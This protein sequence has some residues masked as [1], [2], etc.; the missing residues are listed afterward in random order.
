MN[1]YN[2]E[3]TV[4]LIL[5][6]GGDNEDLIDTITQAE[7]ETLIRALNHYTLTVRRF[8]DNGVPGDADRS[9]DLIDRLR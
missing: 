4:S 1:Q 6:T 7:Y 8:P 2:D 9:K 5:N 3:G